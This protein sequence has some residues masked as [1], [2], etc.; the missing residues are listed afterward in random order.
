MPRRLLRAAPRVG[1]RFSPAAPLAALLVALGG[2]S[3]GAATDALNAVPSISS[4]SPASV[5]RNSPLFT[6]TITGANFSPGTSILWNGV[7]RPAVYVSSTQLTTI[8]VPT[9]VAVTGTVPVAAI[10]TQ[11][12][13]SAPVTFTVGPAAPVVTSVAPSSIAAGSA[14]TSLTVLGSEF[15]TASVVRFNG[16]ARTTTFVSST[17]LSA[18]LTAADLATGALAQ[19]IVSTPNAGASQ[20]VTLTVV[21]PAPAVSATSPAYAAVGAGPV[22]LTVTGTNFVGTSIVRWNGADRATTYVSPTQLTAAIAATDLA[23]LGT[24]SVTVATPAPGGGTTAA[25]PFAVGISS[26]A[27]IAMRANDVVADSGRARIYASVA[28]TDA[29]RA[30]TIA[31]IDPATGTV[32]ATVAI[33]SDPGRLAMSD[34]GQYLYVGL[35]GTGEVARVDLATFTA[36]PKFG[37]GT[38]SFAGTL[39][40]KDIDV[41]PGTPTSVAVARK[42]ANT[43][44][45]HA[46]VAIYDNGV[47]R[48]TVTADSPINSTIAFTTSPATL[49]GAD[50]E[51]TG[52]YFSV[53]AVTAGG[54]SQA[55]TT[56][57]V[58]DGFDTDMVGAG[59]RLYLSNGMVIDP[60]TSTTAAIGR[61][62]FDVF[63]QRAVRPD[64]TNNR[65]VFL[66]VA[67]PYGPAASSRLWACNATTFGSA[68]SVTV[69]GVAGGTGRLARWGTDGLAFPA[70]D[71]L[72][73]VRTSLVTGP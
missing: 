42:Y 43:S 16:T 28:G 39:Y 70:A 67:G 47:R 5:A 48:T 14:A 56:A 73:L 33:G 3:G 10:S 51:T 62:T 45:D 25:L 15:T 59:S 29:T 9:D 2:C 44:P 64:I 61:C 32:E 72:V 23:A 31:R 49:Y 58:I 34:G 30:N 27:T 38:G 17:E 66:S 41:L 18:A 22:T 4:L 53:L 1:P 55:S 20:P 6:L 63:A 8:I 11:G 21:N 35:N 69:P 46:G 13:Q 19:I 24:A 36:G 57:G 65:I 52:N 60:A 26:V 12:R 68:G 40:V 7:T 71:K 50:N 37:L 54:V